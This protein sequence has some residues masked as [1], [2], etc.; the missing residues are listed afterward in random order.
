MALSL[1]GFLPCT[2]AQDKED[3]MVR[4]VFSLLQPS[5]SIGEKEAQS[6]RFR[7]G[8]SYLEPAQ[9]GWFVLWNPYTRL[10]VLNF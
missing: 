8:T 7:K 10:D 4:Q 9:N 5:W 6:K 1:N 2:V 3:L